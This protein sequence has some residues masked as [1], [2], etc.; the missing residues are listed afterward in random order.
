MLARADRALTLF[1]A[2][3]NAILVSGFTI[4]IL[5][6]YAHGP[7]DTPGLDSAVAALTPHLNEQDAV[8]ALLP[9]S[10]LDWIDSYNSA[11]RDIG[12]VMEDPLSDRTAV[13]LEA[14]A[15]QHPRVWL[16]SE[17][18]V[19]GNPAN[20]VEHWLAQH[21][22]IGSETWI[23]GFRLVTY[24]FSAGSESQSIEQRFGDA[25]ILE[26]AAS[27]LAYLNTQPAWLNVD[28]SWR[29]SEP[30]TQSLTVF[31]HLLN[32]DGSLIAQHDGP[33][34][35]GYAP[36]T[37]W[38]PDQ[39]IEDRRALM[40]PADLPA[41]EYRLVVGLYDAATGQRLTLT[42]GSDALLLET[43]YID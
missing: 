38:T 29:A 40:L 39:V 43:L 17:G 19:G 21:G 7:Y 15:R 13:K 22:Y 30:L 32:T 4:F 16:I 26:G 23:E 36:T 2:M 10:Y 8:L 11:P 24:T 18:T 5:T 41:G 6:R 1:I 35:A 27:E 3:A 12:V 9:V 31:T 14:I 37:T 20:G 33:P 34:A 25:V 28:L 42:D